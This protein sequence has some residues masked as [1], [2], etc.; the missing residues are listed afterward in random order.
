M[1]ADP[2][3]AK[4]LRNGMQEGLMSV[5]MKLGTNVSGRDLFG[6]R[7]KKFG[8]REAR[9]RDNDERKR[10]LTDGRHCLWVYLSEDGFIEALVAYG[11]NQPVEILDAIC[12]TFGTEVYTEHDPQYWGCDTQEEWEVA[13]PEIAGQMRW[14]EPNETEPNRIVQILKENAEAVSVVAA[15]LR[16]E[17]PLTNIKVAGTDMGPRN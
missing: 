15:K 10:C 7:L 16:A 5:D 2:S 14:V 12:E 3:N 9:T 6:E 1:L 13:M 4:M 11:M 17:D 8:I